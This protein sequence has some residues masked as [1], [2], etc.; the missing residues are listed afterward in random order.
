LF[1]QLAARYDEAWTNTPAG[2]AQR[3]QVWHTVDGLFHDGERILDIGCGTGEDAAHFAARGAEVYATDASR[4]MID[5]ARKRGGFQTEVCSA[6][7]IAQI[8]GVFDGAISNFGALNCVEDLTQ[9]AEALSTLVRPGGRVAICLLGRFCGWESLYYGARLQWRTAVRRWTGQGVAHGMPVW[10]PTVG[11]VRKAFAC[12]FDLE[13]WTGIG[14]FVPPSYVKLAVGWLAAW[15][16][17]LARLPLVR[18]A[19]DHRLFV[20]ARKSC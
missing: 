3:D 12:G 14:V 4:A 19:G 17:A 6:Q 1:D 16:R 5:V 20:F 15:D 10:Y 13:N 11:E 7:E 9:V 2:R 8:G 18:A